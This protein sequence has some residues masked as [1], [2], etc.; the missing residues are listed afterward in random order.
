MLGMSL[1]SLSLNFLLFQRDIIKSTCSLIVKIKQNKVCVV[2]GDQFFWFFLMQS[3]FYILK[4]ALFGGIFMDLPVTS[5]NFYFSI[6]S[7]C[8]ACVLS[9][10][11]RVWFF[12]TLGTVAQQAPLSMGVSRQEYW[13]GLPC[14]PPE[15]LP[16]PGI[17]SVSPALKA[18]FFVF[19]FFF[20][21]FFYH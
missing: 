4:V 16:N 10:F 18:G 5:F 9:H 21:F 1:T 12:E 7:V 11:N 15:N 17:E 13:S 2:A 19:L 20:L 3:P 8:Y 6:I 14:P